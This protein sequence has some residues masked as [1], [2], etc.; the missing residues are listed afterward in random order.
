SGALAFRL[1]EEPRRTVNSFWSNGAA[2]LITLLWLNNVISSG[3]PGATLLLN[4]LCEGKILLPG[5]VVGNLGET[6]L[7]NFKFRGAKCYTINKSMGQS[8][9]WWAMSIKK[10]G[11][12]YITLAYPIRP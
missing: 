4:I 5:R 3:R 12:I 7:R 2:Y 6:M 9:E 1:K 10:A 8:P 11:V